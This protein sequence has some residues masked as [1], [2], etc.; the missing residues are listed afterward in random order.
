LA[1]TYAAVNTLALF[2][3]EDAF[4][5][6]DTEKLYSWMMS[7]KQEDGGFLMHHGGEE[8]ARSSH[9]GG[10]EF[11]C[12]SAYCAMAIATLLNI[13]T[14]ELVKGTKE[15]CIS[16]QT[17]EGGIAGSPTSAE[18]HGGYAFCI[19]AALCLLS[20]PF[21]LEKHLDLDNLIVSP[22]LVRH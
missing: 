8:D 18:A 21:E 3:G 17:F 19:L 6:I 10:S 15:W 4:E 16:C 9:P 20:G 22:N 13:R 5:M 14:E 7:L 1:P 11:T 2:G 12:R